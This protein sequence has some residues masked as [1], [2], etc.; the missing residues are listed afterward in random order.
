MA[1]YLGIYEFASERFPRESVAYVLVSAKSI[2]MRDPHIAEM[3][4]W[5][6][7]NGH[8]VFS[9]LADTK[10][11]SWVTM[12]S[13]YDIALNDWMKARQSHEMFLF[14]DPNTAFTFKMRFG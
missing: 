4:E 6:E 3:I 10:S 8:G 13:F 14:T 12:Q 11:P 9:F 7:E 1:R 5:I 2:T